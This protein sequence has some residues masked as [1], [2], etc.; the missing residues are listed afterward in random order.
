M[1]EDRFILRQKDKHLLSA[2][3]APLINNVAGIEARC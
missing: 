2:K 1:R 3:S